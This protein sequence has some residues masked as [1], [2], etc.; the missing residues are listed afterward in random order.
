MKTLF[1][2]PRIVTKVDEQKGYEGR[3]GVQARNVVNIPLLF[4]ILKVRHIEALQEH[5]AYVPDSEYESRMGEGI[6]I[7]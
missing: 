1:T 3:K 6:A 5:S 4:K 7:Q 2:F